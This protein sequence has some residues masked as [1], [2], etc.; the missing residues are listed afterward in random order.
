MNLHEEAIQF[1][2]S[3]HLAMRETIA[4]IQAENEVLRAFCLAV[5][6]TLPSDRRKTLECFSM[7]CEMFRSE[8]MKPL[9]LERFDLASQEL[10]HAILSGPEP[11]PPGEP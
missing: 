1:I 9:A 5:A 7:L 11:V 6:Q 10:S 3:D 2:A 8:D 4:V